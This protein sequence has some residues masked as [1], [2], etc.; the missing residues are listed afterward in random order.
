MSKHVA[1]LHRDNE[2]PRRLTQVELDEMNR[3]A[4]RERFLRVVLYRVI[5]RNRKRGSG[6][7]YFWARW[8]WDRSPE[9]LK[10]LTPNTTINA[11]VRL[12]ARNH[13][14]HVRLR[15]LHERA[16]SDWRVWREVRSEYPP[17]PDGAFAHL[18]VFARLKRTLG[19]RCLP[20]YRPQPK[21]V[22]V[23]D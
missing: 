15:T 9:S 17:E 16:Q 8:R 11:S 20:R 22:H 10:W 12:H 7:Q 2:K 5:G 4:R 6:P 13:P 1:T 23:K 19:L 21:P 3:G 18:A 14:E